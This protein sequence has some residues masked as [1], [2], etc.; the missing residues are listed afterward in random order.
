MSKTGILSCMVFLASLS[1]LAYA[2]PDSKG[3]K[4]V[5]YYA[6]VANQA[7]TQR[8]LEECKSRIKT[9]FD[10]EIVMSHENCKNAQIGEI[11]AF[12]KQQRAE[13]AEQKQKH[14]SDALS[15]LPSQDK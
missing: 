14:S 1:G 11:A 12:R 3:A 8:V 7:E 13:I 5:V 10:Y 9:V 2:A 15:S 4:S 6:D